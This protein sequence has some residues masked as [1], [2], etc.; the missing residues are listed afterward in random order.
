MFNRAKRSHPRP[1]VGRAHLLRLTAAQKRCEKDKACRARGRLWYERALKE[2]NN[3][4]TKH[5]PIAVKGRGHAAGEN[6]L[7][8]LW[9]Q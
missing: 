5:Q 4:Q 6:H 2:K 8:E 9:H 7:A 3:K 1:S